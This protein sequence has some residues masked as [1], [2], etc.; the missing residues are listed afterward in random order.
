[1][2]SSYLD[3]IS[4]FDNYSSI[5]RYNNKQSSQFSSLQISKKT[6]LRINEIIY[7]TIKL[8]QI[9]D[10]PTLTTYFVLRLTNSRLS[11]KYTLKKSNQTTQTTIWRMKNSISI[12]YH[13][14][15]AS[16]FACTN[17]NATMDCHLFLHM[18]Y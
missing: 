8:F 2:M 14:I 11:E 13:D 12:V 16:F 7:C 15:K 1:M 4:N 9:V 17:L 3:S 10:I 5:S 6:C 18:S